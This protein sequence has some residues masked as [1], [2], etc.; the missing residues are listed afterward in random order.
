MIRIII[1]SVAWFLSGTLVTW[2]LGFS[3]LASGRVGLI[4]LIIALVYLALLILPIEY[5]RRLF[6]SGPGPEDEFYLHIG[7]LWY[8]PLVAMIWTPLILIIRFLF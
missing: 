2:S 7:C 4:S 3:F 6:F 5:N 8:I 1:L